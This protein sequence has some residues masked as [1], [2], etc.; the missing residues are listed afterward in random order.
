M[1][2]DWL[3]I[4]GL[5]AGFGTILFLNQRQ[6]QQQLGEL[7][8]E[9]AHLQVQAPPDLDRTPLP[10]LA[11]ND[12][13]ATPTGL[14]DGDAELFR[15]VFRQ[16]LEKGLLSEAQSPETQ[17]MIRQALREPTPEVER[18]APAGPPGGDSGGE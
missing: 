2:R 8:Q 15:H 11:P 12:T 1:R 18:K 13:P 3:L 5:L 4:A 17:Q 14:P 7:R 16:T 9:I 10:P 6:F